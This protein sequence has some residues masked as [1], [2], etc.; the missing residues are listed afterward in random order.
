MGENEMNDKNGTVIT[1]H[2]TRYLFVL[3]FSLG[4]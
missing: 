1:P 4:E 2:D 3:P